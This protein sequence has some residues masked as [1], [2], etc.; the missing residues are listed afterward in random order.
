MT[1][2]SEAHAATALASIQEDARFVVRTARALPKLDADQSSVASM[3]MLPS[4][5][6]ITYESRRWL[7]QH[8][9]SAA[10]ILPSESVERVTS[11]RHAAKWLTASK[12]GIDAGL[13]SFRRMRIAH[14]ER[15]TGNTPFLWARPLESDL[16]L[17]RHQGV[18]VLNTHL[19]GLVLGG[20][21]P[22]GLGPE[23]QSVS[24]TI[25]RQAVLLNREHVDGPSFLERMS[26]VTFRDVRSD[27]YFRNSGRSDLEVAGYLHV[28]WCSLAF[29]RLLE[30]VDPDDAGPVFKLQFAG[31]YHVAQSLKLLDPDLATG[32][33]EVAEGDTAR[34]LRNDLVHY[35]P[36]DK[37][38]AFALDPSRPR[39]ALIEHAYG[40]DAS[41]VAEEVRAAIEQLH[42]RLGETLGRAGSLRD[43]DAD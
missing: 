43:R 29:L 30:V 5:A 32:L 1:D 31:L 10:Q 28:L 2:S 9:P 7:E 33:G 3:A 39:L 18:D 16:G 40:R 21:T 11:I 17:Y 4:F 22:D 25:A 34:R 42:G 23:M 35:A 26:A 41:G 15:F 37:T 14:K 38:P 20:Q 36:H 19:V 8:I 27:R 13:E 24:E 6:L 12:A